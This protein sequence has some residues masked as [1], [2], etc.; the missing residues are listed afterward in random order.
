MT[1]IQQYNGPSS[2]LSCEQALGFS[3]LEKKNI[4]NEKWLKNIIYVELEQV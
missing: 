3:S 1:D 4:L 2:T